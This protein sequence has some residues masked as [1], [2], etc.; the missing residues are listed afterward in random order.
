METMTSEFSL[1]D[2]IWTVYEIHLAFLEW[3]TKKESMFQ[4]HLNEDMWQKV[5]QTLAEIAHS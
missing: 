2:S 3:N 5:T 4:T 1:T